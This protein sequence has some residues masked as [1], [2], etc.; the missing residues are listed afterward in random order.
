MVVVRDVRQRLGEAI[1]DA[2]KAQDPPLTQQDLARAV[3]VHQPS[4]SA[5]EL[6]RTMPAPTTVLTLVALLGLDLAVLADPPRVPQTAPDVE[7]LQEAS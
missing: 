5:W 3:G 7:A 4:V 1:R 2:R 6:G